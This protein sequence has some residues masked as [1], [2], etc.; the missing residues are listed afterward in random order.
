MVQNIENGQNIFKIAT[1]ADISTRLNT[2]HIVPN[3]HKMKK[4]FQD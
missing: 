4:Y 3:G 1:I 2:F